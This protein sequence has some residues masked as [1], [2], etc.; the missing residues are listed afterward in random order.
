M[1]GHLWITSTWHSM[2]RC[3]LL[4]NFCWLTGCP[5]RWHCDFLLLTPLYKPLHHAE[6][7]TDFIVPGWVGEEPLLLVTVIHAW[8]PFSIKSLTTS[9][10]LQFRS[11]QSLSRVWLFVTPWTA[12]RQA[13]LVITNSQSLLKLMSFE[14][15]M[16][17]NHLILSHLPG[18]SPG[19]S[20]VFE[21]G[22][23]SARI[24]KQLLN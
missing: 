2:Y 13:S 7:Q 15:V 16:P 4:V 1:S 24:R 18:T 8:V 3:R 23:A 9:W 10:G 12:A 17:S 11:V 21:A 14:S 20:R 19:G 5:T 6:M 22:T